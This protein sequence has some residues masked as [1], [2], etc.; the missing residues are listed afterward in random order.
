[1]GLIG[2]ILKFKEDGK[3]PL[4][5]LD[6]ILA[7]QK[8]RDKGIPK[9]ISGTNYAFGMANSQDDV[10]CRSVPRVSG[11]NYSGTYGGVSAFI[12]GIVLDVLKH[13]SYFESKGYIIKNPLCSVIIA[14]AYKEW[15]IDFIKHLEGEFSCAI[16]D[17]KEKRLI[18]IR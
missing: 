7:I 15:G 4:S 13:K 3:Y 14:V 17:D 11:M 6:R 10:Y 2:G 12:D 9:V 1:M 18:L 8:H 5:V 16:W